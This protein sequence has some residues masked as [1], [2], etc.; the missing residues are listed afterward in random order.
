MYDC[1]SF[2]ISIINKI[3]LLLWKLLY[4]RQANSTHKKKSH[5]QLGGEWEMYMQKNFYYH[6]TEKRDFIE[7]GKRD[8][9]KRRR[10][11]NE[12]RNRRKFLFIL[13][14]IISSFH[15]EYLRSSYFIHTLYAFLCLTEDGN[16]SQVRREREL[17]K[18][19][20]R[21]SV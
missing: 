15:Y 6:K 16:K 5:A 4:E 3:L 7:E 11:W 9:N 17:N 18:K 20:E 12:Q 13:F 14:V 21:Y 2:D 1:V 10:R 8:R 19:K